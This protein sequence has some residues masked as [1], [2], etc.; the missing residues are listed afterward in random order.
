MPRAIGN[1]VT[2]CTL[3]SDGIATFNNTLANVDEAQLEEL[4][5]EWNL[6][7]QTLL[8][9]SVASALFL[10]VEME[11]FLGGHNMPSTEVP[12]PPELGAPS[13]AIPELGAPSAAASV[14][15]VPSYI[16]VKA[17]LPEESTALPEPGAPSAALPLLPALARFL[18]ALELSFAGTSHA[19]L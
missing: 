18:F 6:T 19:L 15:S 7:H 10:V 5:Q 14:P 1:C 3:E 9:H 13:S 11:R 4:E 16:G 2:T 17:A 12:S 8:I